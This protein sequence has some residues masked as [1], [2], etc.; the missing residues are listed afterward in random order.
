MSDDRSGLPEWYRPPKPYEHGNAAGL[1][2]GAYAELRLSE[3]VRDLAPVLEQLVPGF[4]PS[5]APMVALLALAWARLEA[6][7]AAID[8]AGPEEL[9]RL[10]QDE[11][12]WANHAARVM[13]MLGMSPTA[14]A[15]LGLDVAM[16]ARTLT[17]TDLHAQAA[18][19]DAE[20]PAVEDG[21]ATEEPPS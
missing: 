18:V 12:G 8:A 7:S 2:H 19:D 21:E 10:R 6:A 1:R 5:D 13:D 14:R 4:R 16:T 20:R 17:L 3:R 9:Q 15:R 11:R